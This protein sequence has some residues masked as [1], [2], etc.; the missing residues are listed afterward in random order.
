MFKNSYNKMNSVTGSGYFLRMECL[1]QMHFGN[2]I[3]EMK[4]S[5]RH[6]GG[7]IEALPQSISDFTD[8]LVLRSK[9]VATQCKIAAEVPVKFTDREQRLQT[10]QALVAHPKVGAVIDAHLEKLNSSLTVTKWDVYNSITEVTSHERMGDTV[11]EKIDKFSERLLSPD[12]T[13]IPSLVMR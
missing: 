1:N 7:I 3:K 12:Y 4:F 9:L 6:T 13:I 5:E 11:R 10:M 2:L 8:A